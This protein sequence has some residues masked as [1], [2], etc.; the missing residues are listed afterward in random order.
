[1][2]FHPLFQIH[3]SFQSL[4]ILWRPACLCQSQQGSL[5]K[6]EQN[7]NSKTSF[8]ASHNLTNLRNQRLQFSKWNYTSV[9][10]IYTSR[11]NT[12]KALVMTFHCMIHSWTLFCVLVYQS[13]YTLVRPWPSRTFKVKCVK[14]VSARTWDFITA[15]LTYSRLCLTNTSSKPHRYPHPWSSLPVHTAFVISEK[16]WLSF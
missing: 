12:I 15:Y 6:A 4:H 10:L 8:S 1:M 13:I 2:K 3:S 11:P 16:T 14:S 9:Y 7:L 5:Y